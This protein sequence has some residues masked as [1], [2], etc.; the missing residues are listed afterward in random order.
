MLRLALAHWAP[1]RI[2]KRYQV[3][4]YEYTVS[5]RKHVCPTPANNFVI[6]QMRMGTNV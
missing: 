1:P 3:E 6:N 5:V 4:W 2:K